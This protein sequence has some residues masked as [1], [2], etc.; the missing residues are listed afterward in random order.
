M[1]FVDIV[2]VNVFGV[3]ETWEIKKESRTKKEKQW[4]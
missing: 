2:E 1:F 4:L 3:D